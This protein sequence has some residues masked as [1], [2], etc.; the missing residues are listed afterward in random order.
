MKTITSLFIAL[1]S[2]AVFSQNASENGIQIKETQ[3][4]DTYKAGENILVN[5][6]GK[7]RSGYSWR[8]SH[9]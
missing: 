2:L 6:F 8:K 7:R 9:Y 3:Q 1:C 4:D 5:G